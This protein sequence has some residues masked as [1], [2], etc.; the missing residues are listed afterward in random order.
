[1]PCMECV[2]NENGMDGSVMYVVYGIPRCGFENGIEWIHREC[3]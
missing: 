3:S 2:D 1:M